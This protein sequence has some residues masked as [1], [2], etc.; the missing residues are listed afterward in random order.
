MATL[1]RRVLL[2]KTSAGAAAAGALVAMPGL[3]SASVRRPLGRVRSAARAPLAAYV[4]DMT[5]GELTLLVG[6]REIT[7]HDPDLVMRLVQAAQ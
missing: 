5:K 2:K 6:T 3:A 7:V 4:R 1:T